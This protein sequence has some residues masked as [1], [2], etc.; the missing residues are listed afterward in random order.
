MLKLSNPGELV[1]KCISVMDEIKNL[2]RERDEL[3]TE[4]SNMRAKALFENPTDVNG[5]KVITAM[6]T[7]MRPE[8][9][10]KNG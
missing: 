9:A 1:K 8:Y 6:L 10:Q 3:Q 5:V 2:E 4:I 7:N